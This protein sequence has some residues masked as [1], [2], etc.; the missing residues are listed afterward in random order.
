MSCLCIHNPYFTHFSLVGRTRYILRL[1]PDDNKW[2]KGELQWQETFT[3]N[4]KNNYPNS[5]KSR[6]IFMERAHLQFTSKAV[7]NCIA[8]IKNWLISIFP[9]CHN[10]CEDV[11]HTVLF[12]KVAAVPIILC[13]KKSNRMRLARFL[14]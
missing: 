9:I 13:K 1:Y 5:F 14:F 11:I 3:I 4:S 12:V 7:H 10:F 8:G 6:M 2:E